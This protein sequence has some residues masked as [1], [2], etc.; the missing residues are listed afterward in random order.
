MSRR[1][2]FKDDA[3]SLLAD[4]LACLRFYSRLPAPVLACERQPFAMLDFRHAVRMLPVAGAIIGAAGAAALWIASLASLP[5]LAVATLALAALV[6]A[7]G[8]FHEDGLADTADGFGG[9]ATV[10]RKLEIM[11]D[12]RIGTYGGVALLLSLLLRAT[13]LASVYET[14]GAGLAGATLIA[15]AAATRTA[16]LMPLA[17]LD[18]A[19]RDGAAWAAARPAPST[20]AM[21]A[22][23]SVLISLGTLPAGL[24]PLRLALALVATIAGAAAVT[25]IA[26]RQ[27][28]GQT[29]D[30]GGAAQQIGEILFLCVVAS[31]RAL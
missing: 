2:T 7:T 30:V 21:A 27:I 23:L 9:G 11:K 6:L 1:E 12:S 26:Q 19:R 22:T 10:A 16:A 13:L 25:L 28:G 17:I 20:L 5:P 14:G 24:S 3:E 31:Q 8:A 18:P 15:A 29:G 4:L